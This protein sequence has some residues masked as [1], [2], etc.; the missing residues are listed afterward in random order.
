[1]ENKHSWAWWLS[2]LIV[3]LVLAADQALKY[4]VKTNMYLGQEFQ[5]IGD[6][7]ILHFTENNGMA[8]GMEAGGK[9][10]KYFLTFFRI[11]AVA[12][13][14]WYLRSMVQRK[15]HRGL[16]LCISLVLAGAIGNII[17]SVFYAVWFADINPDYYESAYFLG[18]V[19]DM[20][21]F[22]IIHTTWPSWMPWFGGQEF[23][24]FR[25]VFNIAD[26]SISTGIISILVFQKRFFAESTQ[27]SNEEHSEDSGTDT[28]H[29]E[30]KEV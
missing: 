30:E 21:Y 25:P 8:F 16:L 1:M 13:I 28:D 11:L 26:A 17:D 29:I 2:P 4:W 22:P 5:I 12:G 27:E 9:T 20:F 3:F 24:F 15:A 19:V 10:G 6:W 23:I 14:I 7:F 18:R